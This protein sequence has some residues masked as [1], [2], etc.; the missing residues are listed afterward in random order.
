MK[1]HLRYKC[2]FFAFSILY[3]CINVLLLVFGPSKNGRLVQ[4][5]HFVL[6]V[7]IL[8]WS[9]LYM[10]SSTLRLM[11]HEIYGSKIVACL[12]MKASYFL[13]Q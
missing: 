6:P 10:H 11:R 13:G 7:Y 8:P 2:F 5:A 4:C 12:G 1:I 3:I 9:I